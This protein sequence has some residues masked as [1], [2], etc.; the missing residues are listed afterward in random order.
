MPTIALW[1][2]KSAFNNKI[3]GREYHGRNTFTVSY[4]G[5]T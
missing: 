3:E 5:M 2:I 1:P 4:A